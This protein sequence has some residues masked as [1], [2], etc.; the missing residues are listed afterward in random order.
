[1]EKRK[2]LTLPEY[3][4]FLLAIDWYYH[5][6]DDGTAYERGR[7]QHWAAMEY[8]GASPEHKALH[9][10]FEEYHRNVVTG[11]NAGNKLPERPK[12]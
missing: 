6:A 8:A 9:D 10:A 11:E 2:P 1:M 5:M 12:A 4:D 7:R 3:Y